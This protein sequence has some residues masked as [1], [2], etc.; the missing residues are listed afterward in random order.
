MLIVKRLYR[1][2]YEATERFVFDSLLLRQFCRVYWEEVPDDTTLNR[3]ANLIEPRTLEQ[4]HE[5]VVRL[6]REHKVTRGRKLRVDSAVV[7]TTIHHPTDSSLLADGVRVV[8]RLLR[9]AKRVL[10][11]GTDRGGEVFR[12][13]MRSVRRLTQQLHRIARRKGEEAAEELPQAYRRLIQVAK[14]SCAQAL[15]VGAALKGQTD[16]AAT[17]LVDQ[18]EEILPLVEQ[19]IHQTERRVFG[20][21]KVPAT[22]EIVSLF[23]PHT[24]I[25]KRQKSGKATEFGRKMWLEE[26]EEP[27]QDDRYL[28]QSLTDHQR[29][30]VPSRADF[31]LFCAKN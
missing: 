18:L 15:Q 27:G 10:G 30:L 9:R 24:Q 7:E 1:W 28:A 13:R 29:R 20:G 22:E 16:R 19:V 12:T 3:W 14:Q 6:A 25:I 2:S 26:V 21:E 4:I 11:A 5:R 23:E 31:G 17:R 8:S